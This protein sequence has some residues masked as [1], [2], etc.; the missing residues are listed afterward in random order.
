MVAYILNDNDY[1]DTGI[2]LPVIMQTDSSSPPDLSSFYFG[3][4]CG[5]SILSR[6]GHP[7]RVRADIDLTCFRSAVIALRPVSAIGV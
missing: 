7:R 1:G 3:R 2:A 4:A 5:Y 6:N